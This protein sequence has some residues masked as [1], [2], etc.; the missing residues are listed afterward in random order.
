MCEFNTKITIVH[1]LRLTILSAKSKIYSRRRGYLSP[2]N[3]IVL[4]IETALLFISIT[5]S[6]RFGGSFV[7]IQAGFQQTLVRSKGGTV[8]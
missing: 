1:L 6:C 5:Y 7:E 4:E 8:G 2:G 3:S